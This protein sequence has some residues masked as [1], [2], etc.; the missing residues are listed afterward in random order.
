MRQ[1]VLDTE[2][3]GIGHDYGHRIIEIGCVELVDRKLTGKHFHTYLNPLRK[4]DDGAFRVHGISSEFLQDKPLF[5][6]VFQDLLA[7]IEG[8]EV[9]I[10][11]AVFDVGFL[12]AE[13]KH[14]KWSKS[15]EDYC[16]VL[17]TLVFAREKHPGQRN[18]LDALCKRYN[19]DHSN[20]QLHGALLDAELLAFVYLAMTGGQTNLFMSEDL[21]M[22]GRPTNAQS[23]TASLNSNSPVIVADADEL[24]QHAEFVR[25]LVKE[26]GVNRWEE[27]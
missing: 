9:I 13:L 4:V 7:F 21:L 25:F 19:V 18:N 24:A 5:K 20:R 17:D 15:F 14:I 3:T 10:H 6:D 1:V 11:N 12:N 16:T 2:T 8:A 26:S 23:I 27:D 22:E